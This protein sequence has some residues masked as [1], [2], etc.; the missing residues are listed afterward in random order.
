MIKQP[1][2]HINT[3][4][5]ERLSDFLKIQFSLPFQE[6]SSDSFVKRQYMRFVETQKT[7]RTAVGCPYI[8][9]ATVLCQPFLFWNNG[10]IDI[11][12][13]TDYSR[14]SKTG[15]FL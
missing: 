13:V 15:T 2:Y 9:T 5:S 7:W 12:G 11:G 3:P 4:I 10:K 6:H 8:Y 14:K 1:Q